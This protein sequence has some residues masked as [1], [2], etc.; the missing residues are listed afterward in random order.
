MTKLHSTFNYRFDKDY[1]MVKSST[2]TVFYICLM[3]RIFCN[4]FF[5]KIKKK[6]QHTSLCACNIKSMI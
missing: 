4:F 5:I 1:E 6:N 2:E 3:T